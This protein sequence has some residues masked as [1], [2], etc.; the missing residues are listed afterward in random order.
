MEEKETW[1]EEKILSKNQS[2]ASGTRTRTFATRCLP[3]DY[4]VGL[5]VALVNPP[6]RVLTPV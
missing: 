3:L 6:Q 1:K 2:V 5:P 4:P